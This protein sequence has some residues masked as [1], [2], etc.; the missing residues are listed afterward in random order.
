MRTAPTEAKTLVGAW[1]KG[2]FGTVSASLR[3]HFEEHGAEVGA[4]SMLQ[5]LRKAYE[6]GRTV[7]KGA[8]KYLLEDGKVRYEKNGKYVIKGLVDE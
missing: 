2:G 8:T 7:A 6:F 1:G 5:Y 3:Y 4:K